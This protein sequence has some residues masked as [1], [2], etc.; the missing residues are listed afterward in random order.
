MNI[1]FLGFMDCIVA[2]LVNSAHPGISKSSIKKIFLETALV[3]LSLLRKRSFGIWCHMMG[4]NHSLGKHGQ[5]GRDGL[6]ITYI[7]HLPC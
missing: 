1:R 3:P 2:R 4:C 6:C 5:R 7:G